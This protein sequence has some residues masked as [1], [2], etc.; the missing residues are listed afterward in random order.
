MNE[1]LLEVIPV[2]RF[3]AIHLKDGALKMGV[4]EGG[5]KNLVRKARKDGAFILSDTCG[6][7]QSDDRAEVQAFLDS[8]DKQAKSRFS[9]TKSMRNYI[10]EVEGQLSIEDIDDTEDVD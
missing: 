10:S 8:M 3:N 7:W 4:T 6:Y 9:S 5:F 2:G 1:K